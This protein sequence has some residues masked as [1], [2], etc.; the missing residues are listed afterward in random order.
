MWERTK[1]KRRALI[2]RSA[3]RLFAER[4]FEQTTLADIADE[5]E[6]AVRTV[7]GYY[8]SKL[9]LAISFTDGIATRLTAALPATPDADLVDAL[10]RWLAEE[11][12]LFDPELMQLSDAMWAANPDLLALANARLADAAK[13]GNSALIA[14]VGLPADHSATEPCLAAVQ[15]VLGAYFVSFA[16]HPPSPERHDTAIAYLRAIIDAA[17]PPA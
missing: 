15:A 17:K 10:D 14:Q 12:Q 4:G 2:Q 3:M 8:P 6:V 13:A 5:A 16:T 9:D 1:A 11:E 7:T